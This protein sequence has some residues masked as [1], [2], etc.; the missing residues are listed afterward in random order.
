VSVKGSDV[1]CRG[2][3]LIR[4]AVGL[5]RMG[6]EGGL[7][8]GESSRTWWIERG[9]LSGRQDGLMVGKKVPCMRTLL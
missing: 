5:V 4:L 9:R 1:T 3:R 2:H 6:D 7:N 8:S